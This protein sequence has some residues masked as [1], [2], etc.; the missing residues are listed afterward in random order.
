LLSGC[1]FAATAAGS[2]IG[3][4]GGG[5]F[6]ELTVSPP[7][8]NVVLVACD[9]TNGY[10]SSTGG[11][12]WRSFN[13][14]GR[15]RFFA[16][17][18][19][20]P[21][22][23]YAKSIGLWRSTDA[24]ARW[25]LVY[26]DPKLVSG[27]VMHGDHAGEGL[28][29]KLPQPQLVALAVS[30]SDSATFYGAFGDKDSAW[31]SVSRDGGKSWRG[32]T[33]LPQGTHRLIVDPASGRK[34][35]DIYAVGTSAIAARLSGKWVD[36]PSPPGIKELSNLSA[37]FSSAGSATL[38]LLA[39]GRIF[40][41]ERSRKQWRET[42]FPGNAP[43]RTVNA[44]PDHPKIAYA[45]FKGLRESV[46]GSPREYLGVARTDDAGISW[47]VVRKELGTDL[48]PWGDDWIGEFFGSGYAAAP[49][50]LA[51]APH[52]PM[53]VYSTD[54]GRILR[55][56]DG[57][58]HWKGAYSS[59]LKDGT[60][61]GTGVE[62]TNAHGVHF[63][64]FDPKRILISYTD[65][66]LFRSEN[67]GAGWVPS[68]DGVPNAWLNTT[69]WMVF[70]PS[71]RGLA[72]AVMSGIHDLPRVKVFARRPTSSF[73]GGVMVSEDG[74]TTWTKSNSG[75]E[76]TAP[77]HILLD[78]DSP[79]DSRVLYVAACGR[80]VYKSVN[81][82]SKWE[83]KNTGLPEEPLAWR[84]ARDSAGGLYVIL[85]RRKEEVSAE[86]KDEGA[87][88]FSKDGAEHWERVALP[89]GVS[90]PNGLAIDPKH[91]ERLYLAAWGTL[92]AL[93]PQGGG[94]YLSTDR[95]KTWKHVL[96]QDQHIFDVTLDERTDG[97]V[98][99]AGFESSAWR[100]EDAG[101]N[102]KRIPGFNFKWGQHVIPDPHDSSKI[103]ITTYGGGVWHGPADGDP[104]K[105]HDILTPSVSHDRPVAVSAPH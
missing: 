5:S 103:Y 25:E 81:G 7:D 54:Q 76:Q 52:R 31:F 30:P 50:D 38:Y 6:F 33:P 42:A 72:W 41:S 34:T 18:P 104:S 1:A 98:Y 78:P 85:V 75:M 55:S 100:S 60:F 95:G 36:I 63:D 88:Y 70:D 20:N 94:V 24:G 56:D 77:T 3:P 79:P 48:K 96:S 19:R 68:T 90:A 58:E 28:V 80:G 57:G 37:G 11:N 12:S 91:P 59:R 69:Y 21:R 73:A 53:M 46:N 8:P 84:L 74:G 22:I 86:T 4:G 99:A 97:L 15:I 51:V 93:G 2:F 27:M 14:R 9:M 23:I 105:A 29:T 17:D 71:V 83:L 65:I 101:L 62:A 92:T 64:P 61:T 45:S 89:E 102:W 13:L 44:S 40:L 66:G 49:I 87:L 82:G 67:G 43:V 35:P 39:G 32:H 26:P 47:R 10:Y 16:F